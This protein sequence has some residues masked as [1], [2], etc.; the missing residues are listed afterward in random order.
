MDWIN[1]N[2]NPPAKY[3]EVIICS[4]DGQVKS[5]T[6]M[7]NGTFSTYLKVVYWMSMPTPPSELPQDEPKPTPEP[8]K[9][10]R[11]RPKKNG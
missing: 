1:I 5:A 4:N 2:D 8:A 10:K 6:Y 9:K 11:G 7:G 3:Q